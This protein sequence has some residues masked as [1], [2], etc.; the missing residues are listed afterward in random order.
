[1]TLF[2][3]K[4]KS[5]VVDFHMQKEGVW[6]NWFG[7]DEMSKQS[8]LYSYG[9]CRTTDDFQCNGAVPGVTHLR[10]HVLSVVHGNQ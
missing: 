3:D 10:D 1:M 2:E 4:R 7:T 5:F 8:C 9:Y 6:D